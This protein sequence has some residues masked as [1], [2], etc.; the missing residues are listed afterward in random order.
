MKI[1]DPL[2]L[3]T[4]IKMIEAGIVPYE[5]RVRTGIREALMSLPPGERRKARR[6]FR[7]LW[8]KAAKH[9]DREGETISW[10]PPTRLE[11]TSAPG[12]KPTSMQCHERAAMVY[13][14]LM[15]KDPNGA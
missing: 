7:K 6:K 11:R 2:E 10:S 12:S 4:R 13:S 9:R 1:G 8:R 5:R 15:H 14:F 3:L